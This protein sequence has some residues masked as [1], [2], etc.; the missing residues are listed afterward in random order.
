MIAVVTCS[1]TSAVMLGNTLGGIRTPAVDALVAALTGK[2]TG[3]SGFC[4]LFG[5]TVPLTE[6][7]L[8]A[9]YPDTPRSWP[10]GPARPAPR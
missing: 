10:P 8:V 1:C 3:G 4:L 9:L 7:Q 2:T 6:D 5:S